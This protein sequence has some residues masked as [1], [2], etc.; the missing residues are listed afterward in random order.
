MEVW[1]DIK[2]Y[3]GLYQISNCG[4]V[5][6]LKKWSG[7][8]H[9]KKWIDEISILKGTDNGKGYL[10]VGLKKEGI[11]K[12]FFIH[13]LV[14]TYFL[15][16]PLNKKVVN[17]KDFNKH[18]NNVNNLEWVTQKENVNYS[19]ES[20]KHKKSVTHSNTNEKYI[21]FRASK[22]VYRV[23]IDK[24]E[25]GTYKTLEDAIKK[26]DSILKEVI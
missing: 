17:H 1:K 14:A 18:N 5:R 13:R 6:S 10:I 21:S 8:K 25:Y 9:L 12:N 16:N 15:E 26:R 22:A 2:N 11:R 3:E 20:M 7:N 24:K 19:I 4:N 23:I